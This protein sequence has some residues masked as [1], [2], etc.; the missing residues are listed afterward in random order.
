MTRAIIFRARHGSA[1]TGVL[2]LAAG[3]AIAAACM[4]ARGAVAAAADMPA[5]VRITPVAPLQRSATVNTRYKLP[6]EVRVL[7][8]NGN[9]VQGASVTFALGSSANT[10]SD[11]ASAG[12]SFAGGTAQATAMTDASGLATSTLVTAGSTAGT[13]TATA[14]VAGSAVP[15]SFS[16]RNIAGKPATVSAGVASSASTAAGAAFPIRFAVTVTDAGK[17]PVAGALVTFSAP[18]H[19]PS[20]SF[21]GRSRTARVRTDAAGIAV[22]PAFT[23]TVKPGGY[24]VQ[25]IVSG[26]RP[27]VFALVNERSGR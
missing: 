7:D 25:A 6:L 26:A 12:G 13:F 27:A 1:L 18:A 21:A 22:A 16:L 14:A 20:G 10:A 5:S 15:A 17:N 2:M 23:A 3:L 11:T 9:P 4:L 24:I 19:G 8:S